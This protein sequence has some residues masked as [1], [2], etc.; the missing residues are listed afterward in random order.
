MIKKRKP[1]FVVGNIAGRKPSNNDGDGTDRNRSPRNSSVGGRQYDPATYANGGTVSHRRY[2]DSVV[3]EQQ[4]NRPR[5]ASP[6]TA[7]QLRQL[8]SSRSPKN[9][10]VGSRQY[11]PATFAN[12]GRVGG[13][14]YFDNARNG[15]GSG[16][17]RGFNIQT[18][19]KKRLS[20]GGMMKK[21]F[22]K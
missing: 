9:A 12:G 8:D 17:S 14:E 6:S 13:K 11:D 7:N 19:A 18:A 2:P 4:G 20:G 21:S 15:G 3:H 1:N 5:Q 16:R 10:A 22:G